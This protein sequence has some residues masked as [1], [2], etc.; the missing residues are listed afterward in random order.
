MSLAARTRE[1]ARERPW[2]LAALGAGV[3]NYTAA[4]RALDVDGDD[5]AVATALRRFAED[6][7]APDV[8]AGDATVSMRGGVERVDDTDADPD[9]DDDAVLSVGGVR[10][11]DGDGS[12]TAVQA[13]GAVE[14]AALPTVVGRLAA[15]DVAVEA[16]GGA[17]GAVTVVV[18]R[19]DGADAV[20]VVEDA[21]SGRSE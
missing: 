17:D 16:A 2:L 15:A 18:A 7:D 11:R 14:A 19:R 5:E 8:A 12:L 13:E 10:F 6:L 20:R 9:A 3:V 21:L 1:A 4:A